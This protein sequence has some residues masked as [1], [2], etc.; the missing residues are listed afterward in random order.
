MNEKGYLQE[1]AAVIEEHK[2]DAGV[3]HLGLYGQDSGLVTSWQH[4]IEAV[5]EPSKGSLC[6]V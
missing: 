2:G 1:I 3:V 5:A 4:K 6:T